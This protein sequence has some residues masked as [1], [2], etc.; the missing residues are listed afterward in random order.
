M[1]F[2]SLQTKMCMFVRVKMDAC[3]NLQ[4]VTRPLRKKKGSGKLVRILM[5]LASYFAP[6]FSH[7]FVQG[8]TFCVVCVRTST[9]SSS[10]S[11]A[12]RARN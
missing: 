8:V 4:F 6:A 1:V 12:P 11:S 9:S 10:T 2:V 3:L 7:R 5:D